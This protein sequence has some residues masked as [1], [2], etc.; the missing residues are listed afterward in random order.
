MDLTK[1][2]EFKF[3]VFGFKIIQELLFIF[4]IKA[5]DVTV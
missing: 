2:Y 5:P 1:N 3:N 4:S